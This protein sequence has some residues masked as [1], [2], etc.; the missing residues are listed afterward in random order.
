MLVQKSFKKP[1][2]NLVLLNKILSVILNITRHSGACNDYEGN[3]Y[4]SAHCFR[5][6]SFLFSS[7]NRT[8]HRALIHLQFKFLT[9]DFFLQLTLQFCVMILR[10]L[11]GVSNKLFAPSNYGVVF[12]FVLGVFITNLLYPV[13]F[14]HPKN[15]KKIIEP[16]NSTVV[17]VNASGP[18]NVVRILCWIVTSP[19]THT[20]AQLIKETWG[21]RC[22]KLLF[23]SSNQ[24][25]LFLFVFN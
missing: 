6:H 25:R 8:S 22:D 19:P 24:G 10:L 5:R 3:I 13:S 9:F 2:V 1:L 20:R 15:N 7:D 17:S 18:S 16:P 4:E 12:G 11:Y 21:K 23:M 14:N